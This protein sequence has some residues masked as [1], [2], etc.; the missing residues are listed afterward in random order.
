MFILRFLRFILGYVKF[1]VSG[2]FPERFFNLTRMSSAR[3]WDL[4]KSGGR[5]EGCVIASDYKKLK[6]PAKKVG[7]KLHAEKRFG[8]PFLIRRYRKRYGIPA[9]VFVFA[10]LLFRLSSTVWSISIEGNC[11]VSDSEI[12]A[13]LNENGLRTGCITS[14]IN[15]NEL[16]D[17]ILL[18]MPQLSYMS[19]YLNGSVAEITV[20]E[21][22][23][24]MGVIERDR[25]C[26]VISDKKG[27]ILSV[28]I[29]D[30][31]RAVKPGDYVEPGQLLISGA[32]ER[33]LDTKITHAMGKIIAET[34]YEFEVEEK[35]EQTVYAQND[36]NFRRRS[37]RFFPLDIPLYIGRFQGEY[38]LFERQNNLRL[39]GIELPIGIK[40]EYLMGMEAKKVKLDRNQ[41]E[42]LCRIKL[43]FKE[44]A[45]FADG[46]VLSVNE[47]VTETKDGIKLSAV[48]HVKEQIGVE[49]PIEVSEDDPQE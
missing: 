17:K 13:R 19:L 48:F 39:N 20:R 36:N 31:D 40:S 35:T 45:L 43:K 25:P 34:E 26:N 22:A 32:I 1:T 44:L 4:K 27:K 46:E 33:K 47:N 41:A 8:L 37:L 21:P 28:Q 42:K 2:G 24:G 49:A 38:T 14:R 9:G 3:V 5:M 10:A 15:E 23:K 11:T 16:C 18:S 30:G 7:C 29:Y 6:A 12:L